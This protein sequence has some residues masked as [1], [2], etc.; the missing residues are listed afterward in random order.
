MSMVSAAGFLGS[1]G[2][3]MI[4]PQTATTKPAPAERKIA[5]HVHVKILRPAQGLGIIGKRIG[6][7]GDDHVQLV[8]TEIVEQF[9]VLAGLA[10]VVDAGGAV[11][12]GGDGLDLAGDGPLRFIN[13][14]DPGSGAGGLLRLP[15]P[16]PGSLRRPC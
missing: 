8:I 7:L 1:P 13:G 6:G 15:G 9:D 16:G 11:H 3:S 4:S 12:F 10:G 5:V 14:L 2:M